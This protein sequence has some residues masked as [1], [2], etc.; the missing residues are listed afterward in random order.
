MNVRICP[1]SLSGTA[2]AIASKSDVHRLLFCGAQADGPVTIEWSD[3]SPL[4]EDIL[5]TAGVLR[6]MGTGIS[7]GPGRLVLTPGSTVP[8]APVFDCGESGSTLRFLLPLAAARCEQPSFTGRGRLPE[9]PVRELLQAMAQN[10]VTATSDRLPF[11][12]DGPLRPGLFELPGNVSSQ[13]ITGLLLALPGLDGDSEIRLTSPLQSRSYIDITLHALKR[14]GIAVRALP[15]GWYVP[16]NQVFHS[17]GTLTADGDWSNAAFL[18]AAGAIGS[19]PVSV[20]GLSPDSPQGDKQIL[21]VL[22]DAFG[23]TV[24]EAPA[25]DGTFTYTVVPPKHMT[26]G[27]VDVTDIPDAFPIL[28]ALACYAEGPTRFVGGARLRL[29]ESDRIA[30]VAALIRGLGGACEEADDGLTVFGTDETGGLTGGTVDGCN[31]HRVVMAAAIAAAGC[32]GEVLLTGAE[33]VNK[34]YPSF[35]DVFRHLGG[36]VHV[37]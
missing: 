34:S 4:S 27:T 5:A 11:S 2:P 29:K 33:A 23:V 22:L 32:T 9:R 16:G 37:V 10:G 13:Y 19:D 17:P 30:A 31:D 26:G 14:F 24:Q 3:T 28:A 25:E 6:A 12:F 21:K 35:W 8:K 7:E 1:S 36:I 15:N 20:S 18:L